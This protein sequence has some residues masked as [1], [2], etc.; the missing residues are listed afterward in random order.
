MIEEIKKDPETFEKLKDVPK[1][2]KKKSKWALTT[3]VISVN[4]L[5]LSIAR[6]AASGCAMTV[7]KIIQQE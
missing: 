6:C 1:K 4:Q 7:A 2:T 5:K 3:N